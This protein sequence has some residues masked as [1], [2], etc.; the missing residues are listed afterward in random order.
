[1][2]TWTN[3]R[4]NEV[5]DNFVGDPGRYLYD[6]KIC[7]ASEG[8]KQYDT[9]QDAWYFGVWVN[10]ADRKIM[11]YCEGDESLV[12]C[13]TVESFRAELENM[14]EFYGDPPPAFVVIAEGTMTN[15]YD[16]RPSV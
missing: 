13:P 9:S 3:E 4:G 10:V 2:S 6:S 5:T 8:W 1:M 11:T 14:A 15:Y 16:E 12:E 7:P